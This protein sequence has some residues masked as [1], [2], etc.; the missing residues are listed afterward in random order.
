MILRLPS[1][2]DRATAKYYRPRRNLPP[3]SAS[4]SADRE[5]PR[6]MARGLILD[7]TPIDQTPTETR[8]RFRR[9]PSRP[10]APNP[11]AKSGSAAGMGVEP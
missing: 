5:K 10:N 6:D 4:S 2:C 9:Q 8:F 1:E 11:L 3:V 7:R